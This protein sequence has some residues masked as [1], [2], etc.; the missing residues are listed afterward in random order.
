MNSDLENFRKWLIANKLSLNAAKTELM[1]SGSKRLIK[2]ASNV[3]PN[4][5]IENEPI[6]AKL[7]E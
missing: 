4:V 3:H 6:N 2:S 1:L 7:L 5:I